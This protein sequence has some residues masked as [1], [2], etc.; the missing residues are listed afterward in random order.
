[1]FLFC[2]SVKDRR[3]TSPGRKLPWLIISFVPIR[4]VGGAPAC[5][6]QEEEQGALTPVLGCGARFLEALHN[7]PAGA[8]AD[9]PLPAGSPA[10]SENHLEH[11]GRE[12]DRFLQHAFDPP[13]DRQAFPP[14]SPIPNPRQRKPFVS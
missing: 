14:N 13:Q 3:L 7:D 8:V 2:S 5:R 9:L 6:Q 4:V 12:L 10:P 11:R 1:M